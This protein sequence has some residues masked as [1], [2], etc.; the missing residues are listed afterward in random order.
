MKIKNN[1][2]GFTLIELLVVIAIIGLLSSV[3]LASLAGARS[4]ARDT[5]RTAE[6]RS[7][8]NALSLYALSNNGYVPLSA[9]AN[10]SAVPKQYS[11]GPIDCANAGLI[12]NNDNLYDTLINAKAL[13]QKP[14]IDA[15]AGQGYCYVY[16][17]D[18]TIVA[19]ASYDQDG[20]LISTGP[21]AAI[22]SSKVRSAVFAIALENTKTLDGSQAVAGINYGNSTI[23]LNIDLTTGIK[24]NVKVTY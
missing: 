6:M 21:L 23:P 8:E 1:Q 9:Y 22:I 16:I 11:G 4:K 14:N 18:G 3:V 10:W 5:K 17:S 2:E 19:G 24:N 13:P 20:N 7:I 15:Q 12:A